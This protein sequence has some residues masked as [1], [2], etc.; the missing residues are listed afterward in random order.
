MD[1]SGVEFFYT[2][3]PRTH[4][5]GIL[6][7]GHVVNNFMVIPPRAERF[8]IIGKCAAECTSQVSILA[9][10]RNSHN[11]HPQIEIFV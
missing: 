7:L 9:V 2:S 1:S 8:D 5:A 11:F 3:Q 6:N 4:E 10:Y